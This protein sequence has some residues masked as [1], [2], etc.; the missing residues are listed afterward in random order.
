M[1]VLGQLDHAAEAGAIQIGQEVEL[2]LGTLYEDEEHEYIVWKWR[3][4]TR[5]GA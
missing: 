5:Q 4:T 3:P 1:V 2:V